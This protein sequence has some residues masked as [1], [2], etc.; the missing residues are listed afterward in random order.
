MDITD[1]LAGYEHNLPDGSDVRFM[2]YSNQ[3]P[4][5]AVVH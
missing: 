5:I 4:V 3:L 1:K 2:V